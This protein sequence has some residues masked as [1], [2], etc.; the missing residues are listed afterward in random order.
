MKSLL[1]S[2]A[3]ALG[4]LAAED[5]FPAST[6]GKTTCKNVVIPVYTKATNRILLSPP[7][8]L[9]SNIT[10]IAEFLYQ[11]SGEQEVEGNYVLAAQAC[12]PGRPHRSGRNHVLLFAHGNTYGKEYF[13]G[14]Q[15]PPID[16]RK[17]VPYSWVDYAAKAG[18]HTL[19][20]D[21]LGSGQSSH[22]DAVSHVQAP[23]QVAAIHDL[24]TKRLR[25]K[26]AGFASVV[27]VGHSYGSVLGTQL[28]A[29]H[30]ADADG[31]VLTGIA[32]EKEGDDPLPRQLGA[33]HVQAALYDPVRFPPTTYTPGYLVPTVKLARQDTFYSVPGVDFDPAVFDADFALKDTLS[34]GEAATQTKY[35]APEYA[36]P[37]FLTTGR[38]DGVFC[39]NGTST[40]ADCGGD[41]RSGD[42][43]VGFAKEYF[44]ASWAAGRVRTY[45]QEGAGH[46]AQL[47]FSW[48]SAVERVHK[49]LDGPRLP[50]PIKGRRAVRA[51]GGTGVLH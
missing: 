27:F 19:S 42:Q 51:G 29:K 38:R 45:V 2:T 6:G 21:R 47:H 10:A 35:V 39:G 11:N 49:W 15:N 44:P 4:A 34:L 13:S 37:L 43:L 40:Q 23:L 36:G 12:T 22:P 16:N 48:L 9:Y 41:A 33:V 50:G 20:I 30:P 46:C 1:L 26:K 17:A 24:I 5:V 14:Y 25:K 32:K 8:D 18:Y 28:A 31:Y 7:A 3:L